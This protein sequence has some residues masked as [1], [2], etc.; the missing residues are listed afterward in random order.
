MV[1]LVKILMFSI[2]NGL[3]VVELQL[4]VH[5]LEVLEVVFPVRIVIWK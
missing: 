2:V 4:V 5:H 3:K 1:F